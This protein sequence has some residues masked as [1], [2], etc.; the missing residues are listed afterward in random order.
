MV[1]PLAC[2][3][4]LNGCYVQVF[5]VDS[6]EAKGWIGSRIFPMAANIQF[7]FDKNPKNPKAEVLV[8]ALLNE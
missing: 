3:L 1:M 4:D 5:Q 8:K 7:V 2:L 6:L